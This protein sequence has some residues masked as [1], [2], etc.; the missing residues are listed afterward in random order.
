MYIPVFSTDVTSCVGWYT[1]TVD[2]YS[3]EDEASA[4]DNLHCAKNEF[5][6]IQSAGSAIVREGPHTSP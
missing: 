1:T 6:L 2:N 5:D 4:G 3:K